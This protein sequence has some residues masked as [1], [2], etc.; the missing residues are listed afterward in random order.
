MIWKGS[1][2]YSL[3]L[4]ITVRKVSPMS[5]I[6][7]TINGDLTGT[8]Q[9]ELSSADGMTDAR[10]EMNVIPEKRWMALLSPALKSVFLKN[11]K[12]I[13]AEGLLGFQ[14]TLNS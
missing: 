3:S 13:M 9:C 4:D 11:H 7:G 14:A 8:G 5:F 12:R 6:S 2:F 1:F 10:F